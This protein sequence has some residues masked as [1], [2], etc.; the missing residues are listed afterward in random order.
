MKLTDKQLKE[1][2]PHLWSE[3]ESKETQKTFFSFHTPPGNNTFVEFRDKYSND[4]S[5]PAT[6]YQKSLFTTSPLIYQ[7]LDSRNPETIIIH[8]DT[9]GGVFCALRTEGC[10]RARVVLTLGDNDPINFWY[11]ESFM[12]IEN[13]LDDCEEIVRTWE[14]DQREDEEDDL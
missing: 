3:D 12:G 4:F 8:E 14:I 11:T 1:K 7:A 6:R 10:G 2:Y 5:T 9:R 13:Q